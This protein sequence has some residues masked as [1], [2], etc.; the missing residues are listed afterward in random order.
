V[1]NHHFKCPFCPCIF[2]TQADLQKHLGCMGDRK[3]EHLDCYRRTHG[4]IEHGS[5]SGAE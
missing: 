4:R 3:E 5:Y 2:L 1:Q